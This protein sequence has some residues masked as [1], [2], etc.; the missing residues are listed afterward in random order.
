MKYFNKIIPT[1]LVSLFLVSCD[2]DFLLKAPPDALPEDGYYSS[3]DRAIAAINAAY[4]TFQ[5]GSLNSYWMHKAMAGPSDDIT[6]SQTAG[7]EFNNFAYTASDPLL[8]EVYPKLYEGVY[9]SNKVL[10]TVPEIEIDAALKERIVGEA[11]FLRALY[12]WYLTTFWGEV[13]LY[14]Q[15][16]ER[17]DDALIAKSPISEIYEVIIQDLE[18][19]VQS[20]PVSYSESDEGRATRGAA[21]ALL[22][23]VHLYDENYVEAEDWLG[24]VIDSDV[25]ELVPDFETIIH[26]EYPNNAESIFELQFEN[27]PPGGIGNSRVNQNIPRIVGGDGMQQPTQSIV[28]A[29]E[30]GDPRQ[31]YSIFLPGEEFAPQFG[32]EFETWNPEWS[33]TGYS[34]K[35]GLWPVRNQDNSDTNILLIRYADVLLMYAEAA[36]ELNMIDEARDALNQVRQR[37]SVDMPPRTEAETGNQ[38]DMFEAIVHERRVELAF[39]F[40]R[41]F[42]LKRWGLA[43]EV[44]GDVGYTDESHRYFP[45]PQNEIDTNPQL[46]P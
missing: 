21:Q 45:L 44:L 7:T 18:D 3:S 15:T 26:H 40:H 16:F 38:Q 36:N 39:E 42:D 28:D 20:L 37:P 27:S 11:K 25:Y 6:I 13:P 14:T 23:K 46:E 8:W 33:L 43:E 34:M 29:F 4:A 24:R 10:E 1:I 9:R 5:N 35:K 31:S 22:G 2:D 12:Y 17:P 19:A 41:F 32:S 30:N